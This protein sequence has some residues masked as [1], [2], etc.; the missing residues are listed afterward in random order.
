MI[1][2]EPWSSVEHYDDNYRNGFL[3]QL[4]REV[5]PGHAL[6]DLPVR[7]IAWGNGGDALF[8][9]LDGSGRIAQ[10]HL[11]WAHGS[12]RLPWP[13]T[14]IY[15]SLETWAEQAMLPEHREWAA[16]TRAPIGQR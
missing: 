7:L 2:F 4:R 16:E 5:A 10:V 3:D 13:G 14:A 9:L 15:A 11:T 6:Y 8:A 12:E 1:W